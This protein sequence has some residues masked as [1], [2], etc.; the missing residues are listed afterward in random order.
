[1]LLQEH[2]LKSF[3]T[4]EPTFR[5]LPDFVHGMPVARETLRL[6]FVTPMARFQLNP[7]LFKASALLPNRR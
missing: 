5:C 6:A 4:I 2:Y 1:M 7:P 3:Q